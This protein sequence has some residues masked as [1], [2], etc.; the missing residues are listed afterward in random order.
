MRR[1]TFSPYKKMFV[2]FSD[3]EGLSEGAIDDGGPTR[4]LFRLVLTYIKD[5]PMFVGNRKKLSLNAVALENKHYFEAGRIIALS[6]IHGG[7]APHFVSDFLFSL[8][9][10]D[11]NTKPTFEDVEED[12]RST[13]IQLKN[14]DCL[15]DA[16]NIVT[17]N[18][19]FS[20]AGYS[21]IFKIEEIPKVLE[22]TVT[23]FTVTRISDALFQFMEGLK[24]CNVYEYLTKYP[25]LFKRYM[26]NDIIAITAE[27]LD[28]LFE[29]SYSAIG[30]NTRKVEN[31]VITY[32]RDF[33]L[34][35]E[36]NNSQD[37]SSTCSHGKV[38]V[39][40]VMVFATG[41]DHIPP[42]GFRTKPQIEFLHGDSSIYPKANT[43]SLTLQLPVAHTKYEEFT[44]ALNFSIANCNSFGFS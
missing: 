30:S 43:C 17:D 19:I 21:F 18:N 44:N 23:F 33:L 7:P 40:D 35:C 16:Q 14:C 34:D 26:C 22:G 42:L 24:T 13:L 28:N 10:G 15:S 27:D 41:A 11:E 37:I 4:E 5:S 25:H 38:S 3:I 32:F 6:L 2:K 12:V 20:T 9:V 29:V 1:P 31:K 8:I 39:T 36:G